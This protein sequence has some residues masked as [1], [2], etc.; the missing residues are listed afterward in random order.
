MLSRLGCTVSGGGLGRM[1]AWLGS[2][3]P[4]PAKYLLLDERRGGVEVDLVMVEEDMKRAVQDLAGLFLRTNSGRIHRGLFE[5]ILVPGD[6]KGRTP[7][8]RY[9][10][11][12]IKDAHHA[13]LSLYDASVGPPRRHSSHQPLDRQ[14]CAVRPP[15]SRPESNGAVRWGE[16]PREYAQVSTGRRPTL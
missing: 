3:R 16:D 10:T 15:A 2:G 6:P 1:R 12:I 5:Q 11:L 8:T 14:V 9:G 7:V 13:V 4:V